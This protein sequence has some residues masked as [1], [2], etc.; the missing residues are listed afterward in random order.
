M[1]E[2]K[3][4]YVFLRQERRNIGYDR[5]PVWLV[6]DLYFC[7]HCIHYQRVSVE[8]RTPRSD[9]LTEEHVKRLV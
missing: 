4:E 5:N 3:H 6:E 9:S 7:K 8:Q 1:D 2:C